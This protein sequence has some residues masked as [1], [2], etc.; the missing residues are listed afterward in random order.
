MSIHRRTD[1]HGSIKVGA[2]QLQRL[3][4]MM[5]FTMVLRYSILWMLAIFSPQLRDNIHHKMWKPKC[6][7]FLEFSGHKSNWLLLMSSLQNFID[8]F[9]GK[10]FV[11]CMSCIISVE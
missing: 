11:E 3:Q 2:Y 6:H 5:H 4:S 8:Q 1:I 9:S 10:S 7:L